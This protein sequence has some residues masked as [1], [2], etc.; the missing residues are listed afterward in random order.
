[1]TIA[2]LCIDAEKHQVWHSGLLV[3]WPPHFQWPSRLI[4]NSLMPPPLNDKCTHFI[5]TI[6]AWFC[7]SYHDLFLTNGPLCF[8]SVHQ[9][10]SIFNFLKSTLEFMIYNF[11]PCPFLP[12]FQ[13]LSFS[14][15]FLDLLGRNL[16]LNEACNVFSVPVPELNIA[17]KSHIERQI[18]YSI[19]KYLLH[20]L[21]GLSVSSNSSPN[22]FMFK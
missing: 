8:L 21:S 7:F 13:L 10:S 14:A 3:P 19:I 5:L 16:T 20:I 11:N 18:D 22:F 9:Y 6:T 17:R 1:M 12:I 15:F 2:Y 4:S